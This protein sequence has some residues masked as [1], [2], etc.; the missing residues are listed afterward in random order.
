[1]NTIA[2]LRYLAAHGST[3]VLLNCE[4]VQESFYDLFNQNFSSIDQSDG[5][6]LYYANIA[7]G[8]QMKMCFVDPKFQCIVVLK[9]NHVE[10]TPGPYLNRFEKYCFT[11]KSI[12]DDMMQSI[13]KQIVSLVNEVKENVSI[14]H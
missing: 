8:A 6:K 14:G 3:V 4:D 2:S 5:K 10:Q 9:Q 1:M 12:L 7:L 13:P 11:H